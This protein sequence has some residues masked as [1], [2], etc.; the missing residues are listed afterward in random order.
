MTLAGANPGLEN[1]WYVSIRMG[2]DTSAHRQKTYF[3]QQKLI[4]P[5]QNKLIVIIGINA[6]N[7]EL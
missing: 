7:V 3:L 6:Y 2:I 4:T 5:Q 1:Q